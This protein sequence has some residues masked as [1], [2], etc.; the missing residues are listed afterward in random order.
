MSLEVT[1]GRHVQP[2]RWA[3]GLLLALT[4]YRL[5]F[6]TQ[7]ELVPDEA[8]YWLWSKHL[9][10]SYR[11][12]GPAIAWTIA[13]GTGLFGDTVLGIR[14][15][16][17]LLGTGIGALLYWL[18]VQ[19]FDPKTGL[20]C[21]VVASVVPLFAVG[22]ILMTI[23]S[24]S[25]FFW[26]LGLVFFWRAL[27]RPGLSDWWWLGLAIGVGFLAKFT[28]GVQLVCIGLFLLSSPPHRRLIFSR[29]ILV[30]S[31]AF[32]LCLL[33]MLWWNMQTGWIHATALRSRSGVEESFRVHP[34]ELLVFVGS[35]LIVLSP[36]LG[37]GMMIAIFQL[38]WTRSDELR[39]RFLALHTWPLLALFL[40]F[41]LNKAGKV[42]WTAPAFI[43]GL[44]LLVV[45]YRELVERRPAW[46]WG[47]GMALGLG[48][49]MTVIM[50]HTA[51]LHLPPNRDPLRRAQGWA[52]FARHVEA[53]RRLHQADLLI[54]GHYA[55]AS[56]MTFYLPD[57]PVT[58]LGP[59]PYGN[60]QFTLWP[61]YLANS[62]TRALYVSEYPDPPSVAFQKQF[63]RRELVDDFYSQHHG[64]PMTRFQL[65]LCTGATSASDQETPSGFKGRDPSIQPPMLK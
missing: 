56:M 2:W 29:Q 65:Y 16:A 46:E 14:F 26:A 47:I 5:R 62:E 23:D 27:H 48:L 55:Q 39:I 21:V 37:L 34:G 11:D 31:G 53:A 38:A 57:H 6:A 22:S 32:C 17:V 50:H 9:A 19:L 18:A 12:K 24:L 52:D 41:S 43:S 33:P 35:Q 15:F 59:E 58:Y 7:L 42:N 45:Y 25:L 60:S 3:A 44:I 64:R 63:P 54:G 10:A 28:N 4:A 8:Y 36:L 30:M 20:W 49:A 13:L 51:F 1:T 61:G 40:F